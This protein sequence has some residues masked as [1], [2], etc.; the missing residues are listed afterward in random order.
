MISL[1]NPNRLAAEKSPYLLQ[2]AGNPVDWYPWGEEAFAKAQAE[3]KP[4]FLSIGYSTCHWCHVMEHESFENADTA[5]LLNAGFV[6]VK[7]DREE[8]PDVDRIYMSALQ[9]MGIPGG[10]PLSMFLT[11]DRKPFYGGTYFAP[12]NRHERAGFPEVLRR[13]QAIWQH[14]R[15][16]VLE[17]GERIVAYLR[18]LAGPSAV[19]PVETAAM[20]D[21]CF[22]QITRT[23]DAEYGGFGGAPKFPRPVTLR[24]LA[25]YHRRVPGTEAQ[26][27]VLQTLRAMARG[28]IRDHIGGG[29]HRY[30][31]DAAWHVPH[32]EKML[33]DQAQLVHAYLDAAQSSTEA[34]YA[35]V[36]RET[37]DYVLRDLRLP[38]GGFASAED[39]DSPRPEN[40]FEQG[41][42]S[43]YLWTRKEVTQ[44]LGPDGPLFSFAY[45][46]EEDGNVAQDP[47]HEFTGRNILYLAQGVEEVARFSGIGESEAEM[48]LASSRR[49][50]FEA[51]N[52]RPRPLR[53]DKVIAAWNGLMI[54]AFARAARVLACDTYRK[55][56]E[57]AAAFI[58]EALY[59]RETGLLLRRYRDGEAKHEAHLEDYAFLAEGLIDLFETT[60]NP[61]S[62][63]RALALTTTAVDLFWD[64]EH[65]GF[66]DTSGT[67]RLLL[68]RTREQYDGAEP[69]G[70]STAVMNLLRLSAL[71]GSKDFRGKA[72]ATIRAFSP[73]LNKQP[74][75]MPLLAAAAIELLAPPMQVVVVG[76]RGESSTER[77]WQECAKRFL[78][79]AVRVPVYA[80][81]QDELG[82]LI[83]FVAQI[84][85]GT[86]GG[87]A[88][89][90]ADFVCKL[91]VND[92]RELGALL[93]ELQGVA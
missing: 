46:V 63:Q 42:G 40:T 35:D 66:F 6:A 33:Y 60:G 23:F 26:Q 74:S 50:L 77:L 59:D 91:P 67:D 53:D 37:L 90:C 86:E 83:P 57:E 29:F 31:V 72:E 51:R 18:E 20:I 47:H 48:R 56:A 85:Q 88:Y 32:F 75:I 64:G 34:I 43:M 71:T 12:S 62:L 76:T 45:G 5:E 65:G 28:G 58:F 41:E 55:A 17:S 78:P 49:R 61:V 22:D 70:N 11:P 2:H 69:A 25:R 92:P 27:M 54:G 79:H 44:Y 10:W 80:D 8:R 39:A 93:D 9:A 3:D 52:R 36:A 38:G 68:V 73:W 24:F 30:S 4:I 15:S 89:V 16:D 19:A 7:V 84:T 14:K 13:I 21:L 82:R 1:K 81:A 87:T